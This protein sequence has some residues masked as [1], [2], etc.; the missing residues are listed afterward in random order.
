L[1]KGE[2]GFTIERPISHQVGHAIS[3]VQLGNM[4]PDALAKRL[5]IIAV[6]TEGLHQQRNPG[7][8]RHDEFQHDLVEIGPMV[9]AIALSE[10][11][12]ALGGRLIVVVVPIDMKARRVK[13]TIGGR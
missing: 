12:D 8:M 10:T 2:I 13:V 4:I 3:A 11:H 6:A 1:E 9:A 5:G 7:L